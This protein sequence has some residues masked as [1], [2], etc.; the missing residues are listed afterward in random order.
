MVPFPEQRPQ[1]R[2]G[3]HLDPDDG[4]CLMEHVSQLAGLKFTDSPRCTDP[5][6]AALAQLVNDAV[7]DEARPQLLGVA[8]RLASRPRAGT[9][10]APAIVLAA[11][12]L[13]LDYRAERRDLRRHEARARRRATAAGDCSDSS[14]L[15]PR[16][17][18]E[19]YRRGPARHA[20]MCA[21]RVAAEVQPDSARDRLTSAMLAR[22]CPRSSRVMAGIWGRR[23]GRASR[24][25]IRPCAEPAAT[26]D[27]ASGRVL[28]AVVGPM[29]E[30]FGLVE[31]GSRLPLRPGAS[32]RT[33]SRPRPGP[34]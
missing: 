28:A 26:V 6:L 22:C 11:L 18:D 30:V 14:G 25:T 27:V 5:L 12:E 20:L 29:I 23:T 31:L 2:T 10:S 1:L 17:L 21:V 7:S 32:A 16:L 34:D 3:W 13:V 24:T 4:T 15:W 9:G 19:L 33:P 8:G